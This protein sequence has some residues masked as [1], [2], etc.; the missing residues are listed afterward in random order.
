MTYSPFNGKVYI[1]GGWNTDRWYNSQLSFN[2]VVTLSAGTAEATVD[3]EWR[4][5]ELTGVGPC[6]RRGHTCVY[7]NISSPYMAVLGGFYG[8]SK[9]LND[10]YILDLKLNK[11]ERIPVNGIYFPGL[12]WHTSTAIKDKMYTIGGL[13]EENKLNTQIFVL[14]LI[15]LRWSVLNVDV[16][17]FEPRYA[18]SC[19]AFHN[20][21]L[22][23]GGVGAD[24]KR[25]PLSQVWVLT[26][27]KHADDKLCKE[28]TELK[29]P[30]FSMLMELAKFPNL[31]LDMKE[32]TRIDMEY[33][34]LVTLP[35]PPDTVVF[36][37]P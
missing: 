21:L 17:S 27:T 24:R 13:I 30:A 1:I 32:P 26:K 8:Y 22:V 31:G 10:F 20:K 25:L 16:G 19:V 4:K 3:W 5:E 2:D 23:F 18:H 28:P 11:W 33:Y 7:F 6:A 14:S 29:S 15:D 9:F 12:A 34:G 36:A 37:T 35:Q